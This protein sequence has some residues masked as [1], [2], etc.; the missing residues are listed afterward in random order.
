MPKLL[1]IKAPNNTPPPGTLLDMAGEKMV[2]G[3]NPECDLVIPASAVSR[4]HAQVIKSNGSW[5]V[6]DLRSRN[7]TYVNNQ[8]VNP[9]AM[10]RLREGDRLR[11]CD[12]TCMFYDGGAWPQDVPRPP[13]V[14]VE[15]SSDDDVSS[16]VMSTV[17]P[18]TSSYS[19]LES[20]PAERLRVLLEITNSLT[21]TL[22]VESLLPKIIESLFTIFKQ[23]D[24]G[25]VII[26]EE[27]TSKLIPKVIRT[28][29]ERDESS[30]RFSRTIINRCIDEGQAFL[31][32]DATTDDRFSLSQSIS[33]FRIRSVMCAPLRVG[34]GTVFGVIQLD[35]QDRAKKFTND[36]LQLL[37]AVSNQ[38]AV[39]MEN[40]KLHQEMLD[41]Q[42]TEQEMVYAKEVQRCFLP[43]QMPKLV[44]YDF[45]AYYQAART[46]G[47]DF[48]SFVPMINERTVIALGDVAGKGVPA[49]LLMAKLSADVRTSVLSEGD[50][51]AAVCKLNELLQDAGLLDR[52][53]TFVMTVLDP[54]RHK[55]TIVNAGHLAPLLR[56]G[57]GQ[58][59]ELAKG[60]LAG[61]PLGVMDGYPYQALEVELKPGDAFLLY[62]DGIPDSTNEKGEQFGI[63]RVIQTVK[64][65]PGG[66]T[67][68]GKNLI[69]KVDA[70]SAGQPQADDITLVCFGRNS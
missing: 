5:F 7:K 1:V 64:S 21:K 50:I 24:R 59:E 17:E 23:A 4:E 30:A 66:A 19:I 48:Y 56:N 15:E 46:V 43:A 55:L 16:T 3:R 25:F 62:T 42:K 14:V 52:F 69:H 2:I 22:E 32:E 53:V 35:T 58:I 10:V 12:F 49:A 41:R 39:A 47:G 28:R 27:N 54:S 38:A 8:E 57:A 61:L 67:A 65:G 44:G 60:D 9:D 11:I 13:G 63:E 68:L 31:I 29:R 40:A 18:G 36:D 26:R 45:H 70:W 33:D 37:V 51:V 6:K 20:Q 34:E